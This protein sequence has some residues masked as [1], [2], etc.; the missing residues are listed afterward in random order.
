MVVACVVDPFLLCKYKG[1]GSMRIGYSCDPDTIA[2]YCPFF[3]LKEKGK[4]VQNFLDANLIQVAPECR[5]TGRL[6][7]LYRGTFGR[8]ANSQKR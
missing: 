5:D 6:A 8:N 4:Q 3:L 1:S 7:S 2:F